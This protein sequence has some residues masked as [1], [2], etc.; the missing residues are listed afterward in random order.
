MKPE[1]WD[2]LSDRY[3]TWLFAGDAE[4][5]RMRAELA[6]EDPDLS[7]AFDELT[8]TLAE[9]FLETPALVLAAQQT[10][11]VEAALIGSGMTIG[12]YRIVSL[13]ARG[14][15]GDVYRATDERLH[16][17]VALKVLADSRTGEARRVDRFMHEARV[18]ASLDHPNVV[19]IFDVGRFENRAYLVAELLE[20]ETL[21][22]R[23]A[24]GPIPPDEVLRI[25]MEIAQGLAAAHKAGLVHRD[26][27]PDNIFLTQSGITKI[28]DFGIAK[29]V[30]D[31]TVRGGFSTATGVLMGTAG[32]IAPEQIRG[33]D[34][35]R[36]ADLFTFGAVLFEM[37]TG[38]RAFAREHLIESLHAILHDP[39]SDALAE[40]ADV[41]SAL[42]AIVGRL[43]EKAPDARF[44]SAEEVLEALGH[45]DPADVGREPA[46]GAA[47]PRRPRF[48]RRTP[49]RKRVRRAML[50]AAGIAVLAFIAAA[51]WNM[52]G[53][54]DRAE[55]IVRFK[56]NQA[57]ISSSAEL[58]AALAPANAGRLLLI[59]AGTYELDQL[60]TI[61]DG[62]TL[63]GE[64]V[65]LFDSGGHPTGFRPDTRTLLRMSANIGGE[66]VTLGSNVT[67]RNVE[68]E[69]FAGRSGNIL[70]VASRRPNDT[71]TATI[72]ESILSNPNQL[73]IGSGNQL[74]M[75]LWIGTR[76]QN[77]GADPP[78][79]NGSTIS[80]RV[81][82]SIISSP[83]GGGSYF[84][85]NFA[86]N[87]RITLALSRNVFGG[88]IIVN[89]GV[90]RPEAVHDSEV[91]IESAENIYRNEWEDPCAAP[92][93]GWN[94]NGGSGTPIPL[95][96][97]A[98]AI[99][100]RLYVNSV[101]DRIERFTTAISANGSQRF[102]PDALS[103]PP[104]DNLV[105]LHLIGTT[106][107]TP[108]C[109]EALVR[110]I[111]LTGA[112][113]RGSMS[114]GSGNTVR[115]EFR[116]VTGSGRRVNA[117]AHAESLSGPLTGEGQGDG[118][119]LEIVGDPVTFA[120]SNRGIDPA[121]PAEFFTSPAP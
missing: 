4:R 100:N 80:V 42:E 50:P 76:N 23:I 2:S 77:A 121:P 16:R 107:S 87:S 58:L 22:S 7:Q 66:L 99:R 115:V 94:L 30:Q 25:G 38:E 92:A 57:V 15:M 64:G 95:P 28:L 68:I 44:Q 111:K 35:D 26:L 5:Q 47:L 96:G 78:P 37:L 97:L 17:D 48:W 116:D 74:G 45:V 83:L 112:Q 104:V 36:R 39:P 109:A 108:N 72:S 52:Y 20:G 32:Y 119:R 113:S 56:N 31:E 63:Q 59:R 73:N 54:R 12:P 117:Y 43:L 21:R 114:P 53:P 62:M 105:E 55:P 79:D 61:P 98:P 101:G 70:I 89:G 103:S 120:R 8:R 60:I 11:N 67:L 106:I 13:L 41:P 49:L 82:R 81:L 85:F 24:R 69:D 40:C 3:N 6:S 1:L 34:V 88:G 84:A 33:V 102:F 75:G 18:T 90:S 71:V 93:T 10:A 9:G 65:M 91:R 51:T 19:R 29:L 86:A 46:T 110:D 27:K 118:N 14:G